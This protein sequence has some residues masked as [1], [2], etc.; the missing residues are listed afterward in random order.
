MLRWHWKQRP[1]QKS[2]TCHPELVS[3]SKHFTSQT[4]K[5]VR[6]DGFFKYFNF[7]D[8]QSSLL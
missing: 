2:N 6:G 1:S 4:P 8:S 3:G 5:Q 7:W